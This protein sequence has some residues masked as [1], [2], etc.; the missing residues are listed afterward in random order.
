M[1]FAIAPPNTGQPQIWTDRIL[2]LQSEARALDESLGT[3]F[4]QKA[5]LSECYGKHVLTAEFEVIL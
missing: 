3:G 4:R 5:F 2:R 1:S